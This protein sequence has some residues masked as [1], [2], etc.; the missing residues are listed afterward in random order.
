MASR[1]TCNRAPHHSS[2]PAACG[3]LAQRQQ[4]QCRRPPEGLVRHPTGRLGLLA[5]RAEEQRPAG[6]RRRRLVGTHHVRAMVCL[7]IQLRFRSAPGIRGRAGPPVRSPPQGLADGSRTG[8]LLPA[9]RNP[10]GPRLTGREASTSGGQRY[11]APELAAQ[12][13]HRRRRRTAAGARHL[14]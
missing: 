10:E 6:R 1:G 14:A 5:E 3:H 7:R 4:W 11:S 12:A 13:P 8:R 9:P 2:T